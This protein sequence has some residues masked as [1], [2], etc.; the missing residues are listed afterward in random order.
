MYEL[1]LMLNAMCL[2][3]RHLSLVISTGQVLAGGPIDE[4]L[5]ARTNDGIS[6]LAEDAY[7]TAARALELAKAKNDE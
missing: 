6:T 2:E 7:G 1:I 5:L 4:G 3:I